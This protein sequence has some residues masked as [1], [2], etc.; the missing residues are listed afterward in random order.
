MK[1][2]RWQAEW[3]WLAGV[4]LLLVLGFWWFPGQTSDA[5]D[6]FSTAA[7]GK[8]AFFTL[9]ERLTPPATRTVEKLW[10]HL[11]DADTMCILGPARY[12]D[13][14]E[15]DWL[16]DWVSFGK[17]L[18]FAARMDDPAAE[19]MYFG[20]RVVPDERLIDRRNRKKSDTDETESDSAADSDES[21]SKQ[22]DTT[23]S[24]RRPRSLFREAK[25]ETP[26]ATGKFHWLSAG[27][28]ETSN[29]RSEVLVTADGRPQV[30]RLPFGQG[31][32][33]VCSSDYIFTNK[34]LAT[35]ANGLLAFRILEAGNPQAVVFDE[36]LNAS[37]AP[38]VFGLLFDS[39]VRPIT[40]QILLVTV[41]FCWLGFR[42]FG[43]PEVR[44]SAEHRSMTEH[45]I[46][47]GNMHLKA[48]TGSRA[49]H[50]YL[51][52]F[53][54][55]LRLHYAAGS[56]VAEA[57]LL[58]RRAGT[59]EHATAKLLAD[60]RDALGQGRLA[61]GRAAALVRELAAIKHKLDRAK[62]ASN[63]T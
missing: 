48:G 42:R 47:L 22:D 51:D 12:P 4:V 60:V 25:V 7:G 11:G 16:T 38:K 34:S 40:L 43:P 41:L 56:G 58:A 28:I 5:T 53:R 19:L 59:D 49:I 63:G 61:G 26:L 3:A 46:A 27:H 36:S 31:T 13:A 55:E 57:T 54:N 21:E 18:V 52:Y 32:L 2:L 14:A 30:V 8:R 37:G 1:R 50:W 45:A 24:D 10:D 20:V 17:T 9:A 6:S 15:W 29:Q 35:D 23:K 62:G 33:I 39:H 44:I